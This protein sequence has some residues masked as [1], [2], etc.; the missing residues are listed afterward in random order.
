M[1]C[2]RC[3]KPVNGQ[4]TCP[5]CGQVQPVPILATPQPS[6]V[7]QH[8]RVL[9]VLWIA[10]SLISLLGGLVLIVLANTLFVHLR[11]QGAPLFLTPLLSLIGVFVLAKGILCIAAGIAVLQRAA[12]GRMIAL[13]AAC[14]SL[15]NLPFGTALGI[16]TL[17]VLLSAN[18]ERE[19]RQYVADA[20]VALSANA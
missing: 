19:Y 13:I 6:R 12:A 1:F 14:V 7:N 16:Y 5:S 3:G 17:Y 8:A 15:I 10:Y 20:N 2:N 18:S 9:G 11:T 4:T